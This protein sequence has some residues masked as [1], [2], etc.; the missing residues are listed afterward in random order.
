M[1]N[2]KVTVEF[3][4][5]DKGNS[6]EKSNN[7]AKALNK[8][9]E[10]TQQLATGTRTGGQA[11]KASY[12]PT[13]E[14]MAYG[15]ARG[16]MGA[17]GASG[18]DF[19]N[20]AQGLGGLVRLYAT[21]AANI[22]AVSAAFNALSEAMNT[23]NMVQGLNQLG[24]ASGMAL[25]NLAKQFADASGGAIS[26][27]ESM[28]A[29]AK[30]VSSGLSQTQ[31][32]KLGEVA[33]KASQALGVGMSDA[34]SRLTRGITKLEPELLDEIG[35]F[36]KVGTAT[37]DYAKSIGKSATALTDFERRQAFA[38]AVLAEGEKKFSEIDIPTNPYDKLLA[39]LKNTAQGILEVVN[40]A[41]VPL[42]NILS[43][44]PT[45]L[46]AAIAAIGIKITTQALPAIT[47]Y[48]EGLKQAA[49]D[50]QKLSDLRSVAATE[51]YNKAAEPAMQR[52]LEQRAEAYLKKEEA[53]NKLVEKSTRASESGRLVKDFR[54]IMATKD[55]TLIRDEDIAKIE[56]HGKSLRRNVNIYT[57]WAKAAADAKVGALA[58]DKELAKVPDV[59]Q[60]ALGSSVDIALRKKASAD[61]QA[62]SRSIISQA[63]IDTEVEGARAAFTKMTQSLDV[64]KLG[65]ARASFTALSSTL[66]IVTTKALGLAS[67]F[68]NI[69]AVVGIIVTAYQMFTSIFGKN[70]KEA[71]KSKSSLDALEGS[72]DSVTAT[73]DRLNKLPILESLTPN[74]LAAKGTALSNLSASL[75]QALDDVEKEI[76]NRNV[77]DSISNW[78]SGLIG[79][80]TEERITQQLVDAIDGAFKAAS[81]ATQ[82]DDTRKYLA[83]A[84]NLPVD[85]SLAA[86]KVAAKKASPAIRKEVSA[87]LTTIGKEAE[88]SSGSIK[89][90][91]DGLAESTK[92]YQALSNSFKQTDPLS[93]F[94]EDSSKQIM[95]FS[96]ILDSADLP[97]KIALLTAGATDTRFLQLLPLENAKE[98]LAT[99]SS[100]K[101]VNED[102]ASGLN[103]IKLL[104]EGRLQAQQKLDNTAVNSPHA[105]ELRKALTTY[106]TLIV[107]A[108]NYAKT[109]ES[110]LGVKMASIEETFQKSLGSALLS[111]IQQFQAG[112]EQ[113]AKK[114]RL[115][116]E[117]TNLQGIVDPVARV[118]AEGNI[119]IR[120]I[121]IEDDAVRA[122]LALI[123]STDNLRLAIMEQTYLDKLDVSM[124]KTGARDELSARAQDPQLDREFRTLEVSKAMQGKTLKD[125]ENMLKSANTPDVRAAIQGA[126]PLAQTQ[127]AAQQ[128]LQ[129][130]SGKI[131]QV[132]Q[133][134]RFKQIS[135]KMEVDRDKYD[136]DLRELEFKKP[137]LSAAEYAAQRAGLEQKKSLLA[138]EADLRKAE[139]L[140]NTNVANTNLA[141]DRLETER[142][143][144][145]KTAERAISSAL[146]VENL[147]KANDI[148]KKNFVEQ[149]LALDLQKDTLEL[150]QA[151]LAKDL[152]RGAVSQDQ[153]NASKYLYDAE[154]AGITRSTALLA[155]QE[156]YTKS[157]LD[158]R[159]KIAEGGGTAS[160]EQSQA[161]KQA[162]I[163]TNAATAAINR[164]YEQTLKLRD[165][166]KELAERQQGYAQAFGRAFDGM[167]DAIVDFAK[168]G[169]LS[170]TDMISSFIEDLIRL[171]IKQ[172]QMNFIQSQ[173]G[174]SGIVGKLFGATLG[175]STATIGSGA[176]IIDSTATMAG[177]PVFAAKGGA[178]DSGVQAFAKGGAFTNSVVSSP[179]LFKFARGTGLMGEAGPEAI[180][181][182]KRDNNGNLGVRAA[183]QS[184]GN[185]DVVVNNYGND[186][187]ETR[188][189]VD[190]RGNRKI[191]V[192]IGDMNAGELSRSGSASQRA[193]GGTFGLRPQLIR[194]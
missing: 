49:Q 50:A 84:L 18:R 21:Y 70:A 11:V 37:E 148:A 9:L 151:Q 58:F 22:F 162:E 123:K 173:G 48:R 54:E 67:A 1:S 14:S 179:T 23:T 25:G 43:S 65:V 115:E 153:F 172:M 187:A 140:G 96:K 118:K 167:T 81:T 5:A 129:E 103:N 33:K 19:A 128:K 75:S 56:T 168:T 105:T 130:S 189:T 144:S 178:W 143:F 134:T 126:L 77:V 83:L 59:T 97:G 188:E 181:P 174:L 119:S 52:Q 31:F 114:A 98:L 132:E 26:L 101:Q 15:Q 36:T 125:L 3:N 38:N 124:R 32:L 150:K 60:A 80:N 44:S 120:A 107:K 93:K 192:V 6:I 71:E 82:A 78:I 186:R 152:E 111:N 30:A 163:D 154:Q 139:L 116:I 160:P 159:T 13:S 146:E 117:K 158:I 8:T 72:I 40:V 149:N 145:Q 133:D 112:L 104:E 100:L 87:V 66:S 193:L 109:V 90:F 137:G 95:E 110:E 155:E 122:Q 2:S 141:R 190:S 131:A 24:A 89:T 42:V 169:K 16:S 142:A 73:V 63:S 121:K 177:M 4:L 88:R 29:T 76:Q 7:N 45:A 113:A 10:K 161:L 12:S 20:Q 34:V 164:Q 191:E 147:T 165:L 182:L 74:A 57:E 39:S 102:L 46:L 79:T 170:F 62:L 99:A 91:I 53:L 183:G 64:G 108:R 61:R 92:T 176:P 68:G 135:A 184:G 85:A 51:A 28:E 106:D 94:L 35:I 138:P 136:K 86:I 17:T 41:L 156:K 55:V 171:E 175:T 127:A 194:R 157:I 185:V 47:Q 166:N 27:R 180:M 69:F